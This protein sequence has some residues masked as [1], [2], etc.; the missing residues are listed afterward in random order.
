MRSVGEAQGSI[1]VLVH[2]HLA[3]G[4][5]RAPVHPL[6]LHAQVLKAHRVVPINGALVALREDQF[7]IPVP[8]G[9]KGVP[10]CAAG[11]ENGG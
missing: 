9:Y 6:E 11:P 4:Q 8:A 2:D 5:G 1:Q 10:R 7:Q 3:S